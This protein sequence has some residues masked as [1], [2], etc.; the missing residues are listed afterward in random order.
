MP[1]L[2]PKENA[3]IGFM[4]R[5]QSLLAH[6]LFNQAYYIPKFDV[7]ILLCHNYINLAY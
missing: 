6:R 1:T 4:A 7:K 5:Q 2:M 3:N